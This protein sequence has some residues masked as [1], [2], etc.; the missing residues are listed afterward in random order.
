MASGLPD[1]GASLLRV[2]GA[3]ALVIALFLAGVWLFKNWQ[4]LA[5]RPGAA[6]KLSVLEFKSLGQ[7]QALYVVGYEQQRLLIASSASGLTLLSHLPA[8]EEAAP[9]DAPKLSFAEAFQ[10]VL[11]RKS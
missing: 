6:P 1:M 8:A 10:H 4:R 7:K 3:M 5:M 9:D 11:A 2:A